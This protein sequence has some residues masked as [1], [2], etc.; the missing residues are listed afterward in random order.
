MMAT[1][2]RIAE[3]VEEAA[4]DCSAHTYAVRVTYT[5]PPG[6][7]HRLSIIAGLLR[8]MADHTDGFCA[9]RGATD[10]D[11]PT[12]GMIFRFTSDAKRDLF[13]RRITIYLSAG[14]VG[15]LRTVKI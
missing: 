10:D 7:Q 4:A 1:R 3:L 13:I 2:G 15:C 12:P 9:T 8:I 6:K 5:C 11:L 14:V